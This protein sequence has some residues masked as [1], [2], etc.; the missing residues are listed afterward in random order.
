MYAIDWYENHLA[1]L[2]VEVFIALGRIKVARD[3]RQM[4]QNGILAK[5]L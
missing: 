4:R 2:D 5:R 1:R 3:A